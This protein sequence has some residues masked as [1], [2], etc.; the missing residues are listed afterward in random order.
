MSDAF[1]EKAHHRLVASLAA[2]GQ[3]GDARRAYDAYTERM[4]ELGVPCAPFADLL[5]E[6]Q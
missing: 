6:P 5:Q 3:R 2:A 4:N 1:D